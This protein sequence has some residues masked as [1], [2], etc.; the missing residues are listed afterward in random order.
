MASIINA[1]TSGGLIT[2]AD[3]SGILQLQTAGTT[4]VTVDASQNVTFVGSQTLSGGT[5]NGVTFLNGS[6]V[7]TSGS[8]LVFDSS[9]RFLVGA[10]SAAIGHRM[11]VVANTSGQGIGL[12]GRASD[13]FGYISWNANASST[14]YA[15]IASDNTSSLQFGTGGTERARID[16]SG[17]LG[18]GTTSPAARLDVAGSIAVSPGNAQGRIRRTSVNGS[19]GVGIQGNTADTINDTNPGASVVVGGGPITGDAFA[20]RVDLTAY[21]NLTDSTSNIITFQRRTGV[22]TTAE[23]ARI[24]SSGNLLVGTTSLVSAGKIEIATSAATN[25]GLNIKDTSGSNNLTYCAFFNSSGTVAGTITHTGSTTVAY[26]TSSDYRLKENIAPMTGALNTVAQ[27]KPVTYKWKE[28]QTAGQGFIAHELQA[29][30]P[31]CVTGAKD[32][33]DEDGKPVYQGIDVSFLVATLTAAIQE[34]QALIET[35]T[36]RITALEGA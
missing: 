34:Q 11:E 10:S 32:A 35:L 6:K 28:D 17:N 19:F 23:S 2:T 31:D 25:Q 4:A 22:N 36:Q 21:G 1:A 9:D 29:V 8:M 15:R 30:V 18:I 12:R 27:L 7:L 33:V 20:G 16:S 5:A 14:E 13:A 24:D 3:T 26:N